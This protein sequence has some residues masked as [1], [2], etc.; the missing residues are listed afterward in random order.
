[1]AFDLD[2]HVLVIRTDM[3]HYAEA[4]REVATTKG[5]V[6]SRKGYPVYLYSDLAD[7]YEHAGR[8]KGRPGSITMMPVLSMPND[9]ITHPIPDLTGYITE[10]PIVLSREL[11]NH[12]I[13]PPI[14][15]PLSLSRL[16]KDGIG[17]GYTGKDHPPVAS[18]IYAS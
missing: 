3:T 17:E 4:L 16:M 13:Y 14:H 11:H 12:G 18:Q 15:V 6:P 1:M 7:I 5:D 10:G 2:R 8:I 9:D